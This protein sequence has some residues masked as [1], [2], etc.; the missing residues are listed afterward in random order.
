MYNTPAV[1][2]E[3]N[4]IMAL[5]T[6]RSASTFGSVKEAIIGGMTAVEA[7]LNTAALLAKTAEV[8]AAISYMKSLAEAED[9][10]AMRDTHKATLATQVAQVTQ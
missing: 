10:Q 7:I 6:Q 4:S 9:F 3:P 1:I 8:E 2:Y 5:T